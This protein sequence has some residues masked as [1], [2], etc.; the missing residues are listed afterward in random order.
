MGKETILTDANA[1]KSALA[2]EGRTRW[3]VE[4]RLQFIDFKLYWDG[5]INRG[6]IVK[7]FAVSV[8]QASADLFQYQ[9]SAPGNLDYDKSAK[10]YVATS[11]FQPAF[12]TPSADA[13]LAELRLI[14]AGVLE[15][16]E[17]RAFPTPSY[18]VVPLPHRRLDPEI[19]RRLVRA[20]REPHAIEVEYQSLSRPKPVWRWI[21][22]HAL[23]FDGTRWHLR[24]WCHERCAFRDFVAARVLKAKGTKP[25][26]NTASE[27]SGWNEFVTLKIGT[28]PKLNSAAREAI[29]LDYGMKDGVLEIRTRVCLSIYVE[30]TLGLDLDHSKIEPN[31]QQIVLRNRKEVESA[32]SKFS[33]P[34]D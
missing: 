18:A 17:A 12:I 23:G 3:N 20:I 13:Y 5:H 19:L 8:P 1:G 26:E 16:N 11:A 7:F 6:D 33:C 2:R 14:N 34:I 4:R 29:E 24:A 9:E 21:S 27:D 22:P 10:R 28:N 31:R 25:A 15:T 32:R 30:R